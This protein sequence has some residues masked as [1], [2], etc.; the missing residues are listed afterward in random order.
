MTHP[1][2]IVAPWLDSPGPLTVFADHGQEGFGEPLAIMFRPGNAGSNTVADHIE[3]TRLALAQMPRRP[4][5]PVL[6]RADS[7]SGTREFLAWMARPG[8]HGWPTRS[9][10]R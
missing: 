9:G 7:G 3:V 10:S 8:S 4:Q 6:I 1:H 5:R 2:E